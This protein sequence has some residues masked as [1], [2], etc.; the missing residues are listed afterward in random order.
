[1]RIKK[2]ILHRTYTS[3]QRIPVPDLDPTTN[4]DL[5]REIWQKLQ[6][7]MAGHYLKRQD[8]QNTIAFLSFANPSPGM[9]L[10]SVQ[11]QLRTL[12]RVLHIQCHPFP[13]LMN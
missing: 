4:L 6:E 1:M 9:N 2:S 5:H 13:S 11:G 12:R 10:K 3:S 7:K 8:V